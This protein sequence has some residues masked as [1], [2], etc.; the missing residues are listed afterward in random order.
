MPPDGSDFFRDSGDGPPLRILTPL[1]SFEPGGVERIA[2]RLHRAWRAAGVDSHLVVGRTDGAMRRE[3]DGLRYFTL[4][5][6]WL[7]TASWETLWMIASL[8][9]AIRAVRP[10]ILFCAGNTY[11]IVMVAM[12]IL[13]RQNCPPIICKISNDLHRHDLPRPARPFYRLWL[14]LQARMIDR[15]VALAP[16][17]EPEI[18]ALTG[19]PESRVDTIEDPALTIDRLSIAPSSSPGPGTHYLA[20]GR[21]VPQKNFSLLLKAFARAR[22]SGDRLTI[23]GDGAQRAKLEAL[24]ESFGIA[25]SVTFAGHV[26]DPTDYM[27]RADIFVLSSDYEGV[28][29]VLLEALAAGLPTVS[30]DCCASMRSLLANPD[31]GIVTPPRDAEALAAAMAAARNIRFDRPAARRLLRRFT[32]EQ[33]APAYLASM[34]QTSLAAARRHDA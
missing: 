21:L 9:R 11:A 19:V 25:E 10:D 1:H 5:P 27:K 23:L 33:A 14:R 4:S 26:S 24:A 30:T 8:P 32:M 16:A 15:F 13:L 6:R 12:R 28:P 22:Q 17:M 7:P 18:V 29:A 34:R 3:F 31:H 2:L 20:V